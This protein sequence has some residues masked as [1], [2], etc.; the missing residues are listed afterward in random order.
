LFLYGP[1]GACVAL[2]GRIGREYANFGLELDV[3]HLPLMREGFSSAIRRAAPCLRRIRLGNCVLK[4]PAHPRW[5]DTHPP[6]G[7]EGGEIDIPELVAILRPLLDCGF[8]DRNNRGSLLLE[9]T[10]FPGKS[11]DFTVKDSFD[12]LERAWK[13]V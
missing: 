12:R 4:D 10:P 13:S 11:V 6:I 7:F 1:I 2:A 9:M 8:L 3:A 5:E